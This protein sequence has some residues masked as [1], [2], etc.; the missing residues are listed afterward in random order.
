MKKYLFILFILFAAFICAC[1]VSRETSQIEQEYTIDRDQSWFSNYTVSDGQVIIECHL[2][3]NNQSGENKSV[4]L[5]GDF[6]E[7]EKAGLL[8]EKNLIATH[9]SASDQLLFELL[10]GENVFD[11]LFV[12]SWGG[13]DQKAN[14]LLPEIVVV[15]ICYA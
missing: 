13:N 11:V 14:R 9:K 12:G 7:D 15:P 6:S 2:C 8:K 3:L 10:P 5:M 1:S 4:C